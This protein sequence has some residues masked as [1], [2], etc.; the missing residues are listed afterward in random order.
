LIA[1]PPAAKSRLTPALVKPARAT[2]GREV[3]GRAKT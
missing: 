2:A 3:R 1:R